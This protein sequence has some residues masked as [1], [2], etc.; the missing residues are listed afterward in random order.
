MTG[1]TKIATISFEKSM[2]CLC[3]SELMIS[4]ASVDELSEQARKA[5]PES[6]AIFLGIDH[7]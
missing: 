1:S 4:G 2:Q 5:V 6:V 7:N 3:L